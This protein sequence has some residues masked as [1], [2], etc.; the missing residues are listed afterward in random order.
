M[1]SLRK[2]TGSGYV[3]IRT[4]SIGVGNSAA[5]RVLVWNGSAYQEVWRS[6]PPWRVI[7]N[8]RYTPGGSGTDYVIPDWVAADGYP[9]TAYANGL[10]VPR[11][12]TVTVR[13]TVTRTVTT[14]N[15]WGLSLTKNGSVI[16]ALNNAS[17]NSL[18]HSV[19]VSGVA[20]VAGDVLSVRV[21]T[22][23]DTWA[24]VES[25]VVTYL[26]AV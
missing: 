10:L 22:S 12:A 2:W 16:L 15:T 19:S 9:S 23:V 17:P 14:S 6:T 5:Q 1:P 26:E 7:K 24:I 11:P 13:A 25:G 18:T 4:P 21:R 3:E 20:V 8:G